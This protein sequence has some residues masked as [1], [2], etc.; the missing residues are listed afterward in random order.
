[1]QF[2]SRPFIYVNDR[3]G[4]YDGEV[5]EFMYGLEYFPH[6]DAIVP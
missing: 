3:T 4:V 2:I 1:M 6:I 5:G